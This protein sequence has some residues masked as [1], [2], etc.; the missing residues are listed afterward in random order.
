MNQN[1]REKLEHEARKLDL[2]LK[3]LEF[4]MHLSRLHWND[5]VLI[6]GFLIVVVG[7]VFVLI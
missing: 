7:T 4:K 6:V 5:I 2:E 3:W 1:D